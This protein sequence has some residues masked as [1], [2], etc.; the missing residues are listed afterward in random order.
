M[1]YPFHL[2]IQRVESIW[3]E[4]CLLWHPFTSCPKGDQALINKILDGARWQ[5][6]NEYASTTRGPAI[7]RDT[8]LRGIGKRGVTSPINLV[9]EE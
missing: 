4:Q 5:A 9:S 6:A 8:P 2:F 7:S 3:M 1:S